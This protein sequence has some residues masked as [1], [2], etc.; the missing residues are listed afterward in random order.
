MD[1]NWAE[2]M[3]FFWFTI[4]LIYEF[5]S[6]KVLLM[7]FRSFPFDI[8]LLPKVSLNWS[9][10]LYIYIT[11]MIFYLFVWYSFSASV[12]SKN[13]R[14]KAGMIESLTMINLF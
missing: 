7:S 5:A 1:V 12:F 9:F 13:I 3:T 6:S 10:V 4:S 8:P 14:I 11:S 2:D